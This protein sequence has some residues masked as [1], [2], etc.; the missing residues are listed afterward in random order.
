[1]REEL[2]ISKLGPHSF[3][4]PPFEELGFYQCGE[5]TGESARYLSEF[6]TMLGR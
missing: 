2:G 4:T 1:M 5:T 3:P 6:L